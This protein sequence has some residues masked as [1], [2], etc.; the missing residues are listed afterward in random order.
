MSIG[1]EKKDEFINKIKEAI[2]KLQKTLPKQL[3]EADI[4]SIM[5]RLDEN[6]TDTLNARQGMVISL[7]QLIYYGPG[8][9]E[10]S[11]DYSELIEK[12]PYL[13]LLVG[14]RDLAIANHAKQYLYS[15][16]ND[17]KITKDYFVK[18]HAQVVR[19]YEARNKEE[20]Q[21]HDGHE[22]K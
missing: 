9:E 18:S 20:N 21:S 16:G 22:E 12:I 14:N 1:K 8:K 13:S 5:K 15:T 11:I 19:E 3:S 4:E 10:I 17:Y 6:I 2:L 7:G